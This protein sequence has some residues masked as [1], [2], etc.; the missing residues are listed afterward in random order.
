MPLFLK[1]QCNR[2]LLSPGDAAFFKE[3]GY[4]VKKR[5][6]DPASLAPIVDHVWANAPAC[7]DRSDPASWVDPP[8]VS[9][10]HNCPG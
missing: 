6:L 4:L 1:R 7:V 9:G 5:L 3:N 2:T 10:L 8:F